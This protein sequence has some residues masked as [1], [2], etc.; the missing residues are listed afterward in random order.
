MLESLF[1]EAFDVIALATV[2]GVALGFPS[3]YRAATPATCGAAIEVP[4]KD[5]VAVSL[6]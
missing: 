3:R 5:A 4:L 2:A 6:E 1:A